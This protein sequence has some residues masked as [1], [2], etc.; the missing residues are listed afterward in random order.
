V[1]AIVIGVAIYFAYAMDRS[2][3]TEPGPY[4]DCLGRDVPSALG[5][6]DFVGLTQLGGQMRE[7]A[8]VAGSTV[9]GSTNRV[10][11]RLL[12]R[13]L[14]SDAILVFIVMVHQIAA[15]V[16][17]AARGTQVLSTQLTSTTT[18]AL[19][20][21]ASGPSAA[22]TAALGE[23]ALSSTSRQPAGPRSC[24]SNY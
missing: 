7:A 22:S 1:P 11:L 9:A 21:E 6:A 5:S 17:L 23:P 8:Q 12:K 18:Q 10:V 15:V 14:T 3:F 19:V 2:A 16:L 13:S 20:L 4:C 24:S